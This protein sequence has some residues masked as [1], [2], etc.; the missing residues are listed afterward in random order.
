MPTVQPP[1]QQAPMEASVDAARP[2]APA[3]IITQQPRAEPAPDV[4]KEVALRG[5]RLTLGFNCC[6][7]HCSFH[8]G[9][10]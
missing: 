2:G 5:G 1:S 10:C 8:K 4:E 6:H 3:A 7:G 9:C